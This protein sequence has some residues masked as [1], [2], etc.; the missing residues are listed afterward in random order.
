MD[1]SHPSLIEAMGLLPLGQRLRQALVALRGDED[2]PPS[3]YDVSSLAL[4]RPRL[5][6]PRIQNFNVVSRP[7]RRRVRA[8][9]V[10][11]IR[12]PRG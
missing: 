12:C 8:P 5:S 10:L 11:A 6:R 9:G 3:T 2:V 7:G 1:L 4:L